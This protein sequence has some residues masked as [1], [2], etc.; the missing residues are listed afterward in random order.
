MQD[1]DAEASVDGAGVVLAHH[2]RGAACGGGFEVGEDFAVV[3]F[4]E[5]GGDHLEDPPPQDRQRFGVVVGGQP[6]QVLP[7]L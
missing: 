3:G 7:R 1:R 6:D 2:E 4:G 5:V